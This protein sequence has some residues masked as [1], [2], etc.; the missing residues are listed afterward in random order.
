MDWRVRDTCTLLQ[1]IS[2][3]HAFEEAGDGQAA[4]MYSHVGMQWAQLGALY[5]ELQAALNR[6]RGQ[7]L[8][9]GSD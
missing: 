2:K 3:A 9:S 6:W 5:P 8:G 7:M 4:N 1:R